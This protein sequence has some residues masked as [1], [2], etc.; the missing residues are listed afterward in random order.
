MRTFVRTHNL[1]EGK[2]QRYP[3]TAG[4]CLSLQSVFL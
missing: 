2:L 1:G 3:Q 4:P